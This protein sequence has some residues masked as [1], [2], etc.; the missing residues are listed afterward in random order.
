MLQQGAND[1]GEN[2]FQRE[3]ARLHAVLDVFRTVTDGCPRGGK[4]LTHPAYRVA[5][6]QKQATGQSNCHELKH[7]KSPSGNNL[8]DTPGTGAGTAA[9]WRQTVTGAIGKRPNTNV[10]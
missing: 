1:V 5:S 8:A 7:A 9:V 6:R 2:L 3:S 10:S 4:I